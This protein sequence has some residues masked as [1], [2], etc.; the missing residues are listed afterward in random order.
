MTNGD[1]AGLLS[2]A[3]RYRQLS[4]LAPISEPNADIAQLP[5]ADIELRSMII[6]AGPAVRHRETGRLSGIEFALPSRKD[7]MA[8]R[9]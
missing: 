9:L 5:L 3:L 4:A 7:Q 8:S 1:V 6:L 2:D